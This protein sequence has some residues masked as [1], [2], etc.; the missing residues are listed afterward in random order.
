MNVLASHPGQVTIFRGLLGSLI[1]SK[2][3]LSP[4]FNETIVKM[5]HPNEF[6]NSIDIGAKMGFLGCGRKRRT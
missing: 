4:T 3:N 1:V 2:K 6:N 5:N